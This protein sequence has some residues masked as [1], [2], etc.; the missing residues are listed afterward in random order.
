M[1][2]RLFRRFLREEKAAVV[3]EFVI[4]FPIMFSFFLVTIETTFAMVRATMFERSLDLIVRDLRLGIVG[5][6][7]VNALFLEERLCSRTSIFPDCEESVT[8]ELTQI[9]TA[10]WDMPAPGTPCRRRSIEV[11]GDRQDLE[12]NTGGENRLI[13][14]RACMT[15]DTITPLDG[16]FD[17][18]LWASG[19]FVNEPDGET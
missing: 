17:Y 11:D 3:A 1:T 8:I 14:V 9:N 12:Y 5:R 15:I 6:P 2:R 16:G 7:S 4:A 19:A 13:L 18:N 10:T